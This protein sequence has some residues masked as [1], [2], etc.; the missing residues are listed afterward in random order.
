M[1]GQLS[2]K[3]GLRPLKD[4]HPSQR[5]ALG[6]KLYDALGMRLSK[7]GINFGEQGFFYSPIKKN[8]KVSGWYEKQEKGVGFKGG[9]SEGKE[10]KRGFKGGDYN[11]RISLGRKL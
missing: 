8:W 2:K 5:V 9:Y 7:E 4:V 11:F 10:Y 6:K 1:A 3:I